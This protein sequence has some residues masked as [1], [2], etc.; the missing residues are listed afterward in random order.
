MQFDIETTENT[1]SRLLIQRMINY[2]TYLIIL[3]SFLSCFL[4]YLTALPAVERADLKGYFVGNQIIYLDPIVFS[5]VMIGIFV[6]FPLFLYICQ[7]FRQITYTVAFGFSY[8]LVLFLINTTINNGYSRKGTIQETYLSSGVVSEIVVYLIITLFIFIFVFIFSSEKRENERI[9]QGTLIFSAFFSIIAISLILF[10]LLNDAYVG[11]VRIGLEEFLFSS[12]W[13]PTSV[14]DP[15]FGSVTLLVGTFA[16]TVGALVVAVPLGIGSA[17]FISEIAPEEWRV[18]IKPIVELLAG[19]PSVVYGFFGLSVLTVALQNIFFLPSGSSWLAG[20]IILGIMA[21]P[22]VTSVAEDAINAVPREFKEGS[23]ALGAT[24]WHTI[25]K[26]TIPAALSGITAAVILGMGRAIGET[27]AVL[28][29]TGNSQKIPDPLYNFFESIRTIPGSIGIEMGEVPFYSDHYHALFGLGFML[30]VIALIINLSSIYI[31][32]KL[33]AGFKTTTIAQE[34]RSRLS[35]LVFIFS[36]FFLV[37]SLFLFHLSYSSLSLPFSFLPISLPFHPFTRPLPPVTL[38]PL[39][40]FNLSVLFFLICILLLS[41]SSYIPENIKNYLVHTSRV[42][43]FI[44]A[45]YM[46]WYYYSLVGVLLFVLFAG[47][48]VGYK[49]ITSRTVLNL[50]PL[51]I[52]LFVYIFVFV[53]E[54][55]ALFVLGFSIYVIIKYAFGRLEP[56]SIQRVAYGCVYATILTVMITLS[57][58]LVDIIVKGLGALSIEF[59]P[60]A[61]ESGAAAADLGLL[62]FVLILFYI[63]FGGVLFYYA[64]TKK[65]TDR[66]EILIALIGGIVF[67]PILFI[68]IVIYDF[69]NIFITPILHGFG[70]IVFGWYVSFGSGAFTFVSYFLGVGVIIYY[71]RFYKKAT[72]WPLRNAFI[73]GL[74][75]PPIILLVLILYDNFIKELVMWFGLLEFAFI[76]F[77]F[78]FLVI[79]LYFNR[80]KDFTDWPKIRNA[81]SAGFL[82]PSLLFFG[83][84]LYDNLLKSFGRP[85]VEEYVFL[86]NIPF[87]TQLIT[88]PIIDI[89]FLT[90]RVRDGGLAGGIYPAI[91]GTFYLIVGAILLAL[92]IGMAAAIY[93]HEY[94]SEGRITQVVR[95]GFDLLNGTPS[96]VYGLFGMAFLVLFLSWGRCMLAGQITLGLMILPTILRT[97]EESLKSVPDSLREG[98]MALGATKWKTIRKI[99]LPSSLPGIITGAI[100]SIG[101]AAGETAPI[102]FTAVVLYQRYLPDSLFKPVQA[103]PFHLFY[104]ATAVPQSYLN[105]Y[106]SALV[107]MVL[108]CSLY[109]IAI[110]LRNHYQKQV[111]W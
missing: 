5:L 19:I 79:A 14:L 10:F 105:R 93:L 6:T 103:L 2:I 75:V 3:V 102:M 56:K 1:L 18:I 40:L 17:I 109:L 85:I 45:L 35:P 59:A 16:V 36:G 82:L 77:L 66:R 89:P 28:M 47:I 68:V 31:M 23:L 43:V 37:L 99:V 90:D 60:S 70:L 76:S 50:A 97:T 32:G 61:E 73:E 106:G 13:R 53:T 34:K 81:L 74:L 62:G 27:M 54:S 84:I 33:R 12:R 39:A 78:G 92:P 72:D 64:F 4:A 48:L 98:S 11:F 49:Y 110:L 20:S 83:I 38:P 55:L 52:G 108:V 63:G 7:S 29:V 57:I 94:K 26:V 80:N 86:Q 41:S 25:Q 24:N 101:R 65:L 111:K 22:T 100:L 21:L 67:P 104:L 58:I 15:E 46:V 9:I 71:Y 44:Y 87:L 91:V 51:G 30:L 69:Y 95:V 8:G 96:I 42:S 107:L 88:E